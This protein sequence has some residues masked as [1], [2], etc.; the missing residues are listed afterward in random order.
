[1]RTEK[2][3]IPCRDGCPVQV[4]PSPS[5]AENLSR[6]NPRGVCV[7]IRMAEAG[8]FHDA[9]LVRIRQPYRTGGAALPVV[10]EKRRDLRLWCEFCR[11]AFPSPVRDACGPR[12]SSDI[13]REQAFQ[14]A[15]VNCNDVIQE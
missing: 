7:Y 5:S 4:I 2:S 3:A 15:F 11:L 12:G 14:V 1:M 13:L 9:T 6:R 8:R 10:H